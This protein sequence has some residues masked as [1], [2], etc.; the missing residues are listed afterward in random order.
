[1]AKGCEKYPKDRYAKNDGMGSVKNPTAP[2]NVSG[3]E[4]M[5]TGRAGGK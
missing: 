4:K 1:M 5:K 3:S 2:K